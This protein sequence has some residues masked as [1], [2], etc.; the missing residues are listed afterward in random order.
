MELE[1]IT[2]ALDRDLDL[3]DLLVKKIHCSQTHKDPLHR[4]A[5]QI[6]DTGSRP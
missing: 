1:E 5:E 6:V 2:S 3:G 4:P